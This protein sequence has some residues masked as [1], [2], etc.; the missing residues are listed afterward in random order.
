MDI[1]APGVLVPTTDRQANV[2]YN[3]YIHIHTNLGGN[4]RASDYTD[5]DYTVWFDGTSA[6][7]PHIAGVAA[8]MLS[9][10]P[11]LTGKQVV[12]IIEGTAQKVRQGTGAGYY[13]YAT[14]SGRPNGT[15]NNEMGY[16]LV[17]A[18]EAVSAASFSASLPRLISGP[19][20]TVVQRQ[21]AYH[22][23]GSVPSGATFSGWTITP[24]TG[25]IT[26]GTGDSAYIKFSTAGQYTVMAKF[27]LPGNVPY[28]ISQTVEVLSSPPS[29]PYIVV[30]P[31][32]AQWYPGA[33]FQVVVRG[34]RQPGV[35][36]EWW[37]GSYIDYFDYSDVLSGQYYVD[38][39]P[40]FYGFGQEYMTVKCTAILNG[41][42]S[43]E[44][45]ELYLTLDWDWNDYRSAPANNQG[46]DSLKVTNRQIPA[47]RRSSV[48]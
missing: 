37:G 40:P 19:R 7:A 3:P 32:G 28:V 23:V 22:Y 12:D 27:I 29:T 20:G 38:L 34:P 33:F 46:G 14:T 26:V 41:V 35:F 8:L 10:N 30:N 2:G 1:V 48:E 13:N 42:R 17:D 5:Q 15:W 47:G 31:P 18:Y 9:A 44:S 25:T 43:E 4:K 16:G 11:N 45:N 36:Y 21:E 24:S 39:I 6:A